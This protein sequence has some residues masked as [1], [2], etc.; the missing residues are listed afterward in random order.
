MQAV[1][2]KPEVDTS[3]FTRVFKVGTVASGNGGYLPVWITVEFG[4]DRLNPGKPGP[5]LSITG[6]I[7]RQS[8]GQIDM[9]F[10]GK[11]AYRI[12]HFTPAW[13]HA[14][15]STL[16]RVWS[17][18]HLNGMRAGTPDQTDAIRTFLKG[19]QYPEGDYTHQCAYLA[20]LDL[21]IDA[22]DYGD[23]SGYWPYKYGSAWLFALVPQ[24]A[25]DFLR[26]IENTP[27]PPSY[28]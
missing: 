24:A 11:Y 19:T 16:R 27:N 25:I 13:D 23:G 8:F 22:Y 4:P 17:R 14:R 10:E 2:S 1:I 9:S 20:S 21:L 7:G 3:A 18:W 28:L 15:F 12:A 26:A 5:V 6:A